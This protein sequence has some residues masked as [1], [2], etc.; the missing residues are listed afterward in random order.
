MSIYTVANLSGNSAKLYRNKEQIMAEETSKEQKQV[1]EDE[2][3]P[4]TRAVEANHD[5]QASLEKGRN[6]AEGKSP[7]AAA[8]SGASTAEEHV[9]GTSDPDASDLPSAR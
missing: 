9:P 8:G 6:A 1:S 3:N 2:Q 7:N 4:A 5:P